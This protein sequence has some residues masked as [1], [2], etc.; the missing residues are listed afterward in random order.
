MGN[1]KAFAAGLA[2]VLAAMGWA[3]LHNAVWHWL[4]GGSLW[5]L[6]GV[7]A[8]GIILPGFMFALYLDLRPTPHGQGKQ[9]RG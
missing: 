4:L 8:T 7:L 1:T 6:A 3:W 2:F 5:V 9:G